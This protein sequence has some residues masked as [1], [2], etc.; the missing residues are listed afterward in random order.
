[1]EFM[2]G[3]RVR[4]KEYNDIPETHRAKALGRMCGEVGTIINKFYS[5]V[6]GSYA[7]K[8]QFDNYPRPSA[9][10]W[11]EE[12]LA[13]YVECPT[14]YLYEF[15]N[16][17]NMVVARL[18]EVTEDTKTEIARGHGHIMHE[19]ALGIAQASSYALKKIYEKMNGGALI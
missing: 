12:H 4:V 14:E 19:G 1:M 7:Y 5:E 10:M 15:D 17:E 18:Y 2:I 8:V 6:D 11:G 3:D 16:L 9:K 13:L